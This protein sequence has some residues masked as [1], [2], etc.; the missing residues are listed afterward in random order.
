MADEVSRSARPWPM[1]TRWSGSWPGLQ[2]CSPG[3]RSG[4]SAA[5]VKDGKASEPPHAHRPSE[6]AADRSAAAPPVGAAGA[7]HARGRVLPWSP[8]PQRPPARLR[9]C[10]SVTRRDSHTSGL[11]EMALQPARTSGTNNNAQALLVGALPVFTQSRVPR[12]AGGVCPSLCRLSPQRGFA[13]TAPSP[14]LSSDGEG[15]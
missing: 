3:L 10:I 13:G 14:G 6:T 8:A 9:L 1:D 15:S 4:H 5:P 12:G 2:G 11:N 7:P